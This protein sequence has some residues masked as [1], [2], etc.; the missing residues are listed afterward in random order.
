M[1]GGSST[2]SPPTCS[3]SRATPR[4][5]GSRATSATT[6]PTGTSGSGPTPTSPTACGT[7]RSC[8]TEP[9]RPVTDPFE[10]PNGRRTFASDNWAGVHA[11]VLEAVARANTG[12]TP[13]YGADPC[14]LYTSDAA[15]EEDSVDL[16]GRRI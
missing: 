5:D 8:G 4:S 15:D 13:D 10:P 3:P 6:R 1:T 11:E 2:A 16:G 14:L 9:G 7:S 12:H